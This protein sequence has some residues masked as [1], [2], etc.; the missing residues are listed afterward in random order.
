LSEVKS[1]IGGFVFRGWRGVGV[2]E[3]ALSWVSCHVD[4]VALGRRLRGHVGVDAFGC[5]GVGGW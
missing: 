4:C 1:L 5:C 2:F 3:V